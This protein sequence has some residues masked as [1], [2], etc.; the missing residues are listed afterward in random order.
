MTHTK[1]KTKQKDGNL[2]NQYK[3]EYCAILNGKT[4]YKFSYIKIG[5]GK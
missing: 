4:K 5:C 3:Q 2:K 1:K